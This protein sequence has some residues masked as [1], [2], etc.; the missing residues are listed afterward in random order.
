MKENQNNDQHDLS[1]VKKSL[2]ED[3]NKKIAEVDQRKADLQKEMEEINQQKLDYIHEHEKMPNW[4]V[5][6]PLDENLKKF[7]ALIY[8]KYQ[9]L[10]QI[11][12]DIQPE[13]KKK[14][15]EAWSQAEQEFRDGMAEEVGKY[16]KAMRTLY[17]MYVVMI[18]K[19]NDFLHLRE[20]FSA[21]YNFGP[22]ELPFFSVLP[23]YDKEA[24]NFFGKV[25]HDNDIFWG[26][27]NGVSRG[28]ANGLNRVPK[29]ELVGG[30]A[31]A[32]IF[33]TAEQSQ[34]MHP[35]TLYGFAGI[36][37]LTEKN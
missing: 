24:K 36:P 32:A 33:P 18:E 9:Q 20:E 6:K 16:Y 3:I 27:M 8:Y 11:S 23:V 15:K 35:T 17:E 25:A 22:G 12:L 5:L 7:D 37:D 2:L 30:S 1:S 10:K 28:L 29:A 21:R 26:E 34:K 4:K 19:Q 14:A 13:E 31:L